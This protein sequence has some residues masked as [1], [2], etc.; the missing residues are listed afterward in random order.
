MNDES[1][2]KKIISDEKPQSIEKSVSDE[3]KAHA[4]NIVERFAEDNKTPVI[5]DKLPTEIAPSGD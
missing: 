3:I 2:T 5:T 4:Y 1:F